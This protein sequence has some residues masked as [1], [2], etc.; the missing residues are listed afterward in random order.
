MF[1]FGPSITEGSEPYVH[2]VL[3]Y[4]CDG[5]SEADLGPGGACHSQSD[6]INS[7][8]GSQGILIAAWAIGG[9]V[10]LININNFIVPS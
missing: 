6:E 2:H 4:T 3:V 5:L 9:V 10:S 7:C 1:Q 8:R